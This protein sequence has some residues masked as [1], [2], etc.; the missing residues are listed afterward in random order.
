[1][2]DTH[3][4]VHTLSHSGVLKYIEEHLNQRERERLENLPDERN[5][6]FVAVSDNVADERGLIFAVFIWRKGQFSGFIT[7]KQ[8]LGA[9]WLDVVQPMTGLYSAIQ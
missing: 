4:H 6:V 2:E 5:A 9:P 1:M 8:I 3:G 7:D